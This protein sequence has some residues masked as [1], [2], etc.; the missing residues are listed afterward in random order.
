MKQLKWSI[1]ALLMIGTAGYAGGDLGPLTVYESEDEMAAEQA[2]TVEEP[3]YET[4]EPQKPL[5]VPAPQAVST[6]G[7]YAGLGITGVNYKSNCDCPKN[8]T[9]DVN[10]GGTLRVG[11]DF[12]Q[13]V[14]IEARGTKTNGDA[15]VDHAGLYVKPMYSIANSVN[16]YGLA[17]VAKT[18]VKGDLPHVDSESFAAGA[19]IEV[20]LSNDVPKEGRYTRPFDGTGDQET[21][22]GLFVDYERMILKNNAPDLDAVSAGVTY[23][24]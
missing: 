13:Y 12:N 22:I 8:D 24:F 3:V 7:F 2:A 19:G 4:P 1:M 23:D 17:G 20:D 21:G 15:D 14:G 16:L 9:K 11:Y 10:Y 5:I 18:K 6:N